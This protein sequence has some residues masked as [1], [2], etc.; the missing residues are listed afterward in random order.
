MDGVCP[1]FSD[2]INKNG[3]IFSQK[4]KKKART[5]TSSSTTSSYILEQQRSLSLSLASIERNEI[6]K[7]NLIKIKNKREKAKKTRLS[8]NPHRITPSVAAL[9]LDR[10]LLIDL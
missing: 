5:Q 4:K 9:R 2:L 3:L 8:L 6:R 7:I 1:S 10:C